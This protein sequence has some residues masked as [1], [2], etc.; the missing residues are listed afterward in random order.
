MNPRPGTAQGAVERR[1]NRP[2]D[3]PSGYLSVAGRAL[4]V[5]FVLLA[6][7]LPQGESRAASDTSSTAAP[8]RQWVKTAD[9][10]IRDGKV[11][12]ALSRL[13]EVNQSDNADWHNLMGYAF[14]KQ[15]PPDLERSEFHYAS[16]LRIKPDH[17]GALEYYGEL[18]LMKNDLPGAE[19]ML[20]RLNRACTFGCSEL[21]DLRE[22]IARYRKSR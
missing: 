7:M 6:A 16:A 8:D 9:D 2:G 11:A 19:A 17:R 5:V 10:L 12:D 20:Q 22:A 14:R 4:C 3:G 13:R 18:L 1:A 15:T 21:R